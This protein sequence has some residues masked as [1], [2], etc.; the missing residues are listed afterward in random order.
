MYHTE[1]SF[2]GLGAQNVA[3]LF[4]LAQRPSMQRN[5]SKSVLSYIAY[6]ERHRYSDLIPVR[7]RR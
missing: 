4:F 7:S 5:A 1:T 6:R 3:D 2:R